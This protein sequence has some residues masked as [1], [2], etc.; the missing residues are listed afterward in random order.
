MAQPFTA[1]S[2]SFN[3]TL[4]LAITTITA[5]PGMMVETYTAKGLNTDMHVQ[6]TQ[7]GTATAG[8]RIVEA[9]ASAQD[10][11]EITWEN[12]NATSQ[13]LGTVSINIVAF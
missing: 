9:R 7:L 5:A 2:P 13:A 6:A 12:L 1:Y 4:S 10:V 3:Q 11:L 8:V